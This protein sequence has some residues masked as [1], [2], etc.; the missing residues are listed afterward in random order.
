MA[1]FIFRIMFKFFLNKKKTQKIHFDGTRPK[2]ALKSAKNCE[3]NVLMAHFN[4]N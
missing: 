3:K 1:Y 2:K 4:E